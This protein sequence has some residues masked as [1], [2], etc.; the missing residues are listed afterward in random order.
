MFVCIDDERAP[1][2]TL[3][4][5][6]MSSKVEARSSFGG[7]RRECVGPVQVNGGEANG[8]EGTVSVPLGPIL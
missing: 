8:V 3:V 6:G 4:R 7:L 2:A 5:V 1:D